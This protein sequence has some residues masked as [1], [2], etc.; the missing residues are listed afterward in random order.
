MIIA[1]SQS[2]KSRG[3]LC[4]AA[5]LY[6]KIEDLLRSFASLSQIHYHPAVKNLV[7]QTAGSIVEG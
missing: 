6:H 1:R 5:D 2:A 7:N 3:T 4:S